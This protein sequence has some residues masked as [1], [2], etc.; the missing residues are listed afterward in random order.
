M[1]GVH[2]QSDQT[3]QYSPISCCVDRPISAGLGTPEKQRVLHE[4]G[5]ES[6]TSQLLFLMLE[7]F[8]GIERCAYAQEHRMGI[9]RQSA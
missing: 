9:G 3:F 1:P 7:G 2:L 6:L 4:A 8:G 5:I